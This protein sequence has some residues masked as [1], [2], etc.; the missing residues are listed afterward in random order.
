VFPQEKFLPIAA[1]FMASLWFSNAAYVYLSVSFIQILKAFMP[2]SVYLHGICYGVEGDFSLKKI[3]VL[4]IISFGV[5]TAS[6]GEINFSWIGFT[7]Q[8]LGIAA[9][10]NRLLLSQKLL[11]GA[12]FKLNPITTLYY[13]SPL[14][15]SFLSIAWLVLESSDMLG[16]GLGAFS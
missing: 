15:A 8:A 16:V 3:V 13:V 7:F 9:E 4:L 12:S 5:A 2:A 6:L 11:Q 1:L 10:S 14:S